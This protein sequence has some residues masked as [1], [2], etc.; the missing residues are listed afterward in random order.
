MDASWRVFLVGLVSVTR[1]GCARRRPSSAGT[2]VGIE[3]LRART[4]LHV[5]AAAAIGVLVAL[6]AGQL[7]VSGLIFGTS[8]LI[9]VWALLAPAAALAAAGIDDRLGRRPRRTARGHGDVDRWSADSAAPPSCSAAYSAI[10]LTSSKPHQ[11]PGVRFLAAA[12]PCAVAAAA[13]L[14][15]RT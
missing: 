11:G 15:N 14:P 1:T 12:V 3:P 2:K 10:W 4:P 7:L 13:L 8:A 6:A 9:G 5:P